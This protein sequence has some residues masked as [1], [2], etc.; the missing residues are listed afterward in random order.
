MTP[1]LLGRLFLLVHSDPYTYVCVCL[2]LGIFA[3]IAVI[4]SMDR[5]ID[6]DPADVEDRGE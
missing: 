6:H 2:A 4:R 5:Q 3:F 1:D